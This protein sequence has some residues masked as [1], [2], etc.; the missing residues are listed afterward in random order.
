MVYNRGVCIWNIS[1][2]GLVV[3]K[4]QI[5]YADPPWRYDNPKDNDPK[6]GGITYHTM[7]IDEIK[8]LP[9]Q[10]ITDKDCLLFMWATMPKLIE[11]LDVIKAWGFK[12]TTCAFVW[13]KQNPVG[14]GIYSGMGHWT[15]GNA[16]LCLL[17]KKGIP[18]RFEKNVKQICLAHRSSHSKK[19]D[20][21]RDRIVRL[22]GDLPRIELFARE[23]VDN[24]DAMGYNID[25]KDI[26]EQL[27]GRDS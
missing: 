9:V 25:G 15:N 27:N 22:A 18:K 19:P 17:A 1:F 16:E 24:W 14:D 7:T 3:L 8:S 20:E 4:Y 5:I 2:S 13:V 12:Y 26:R 11:A 21:I 23:K 10:N 6:M